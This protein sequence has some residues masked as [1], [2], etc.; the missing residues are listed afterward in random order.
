MTFLPLPPPALSPSEKHQPI[1]LS[2]QA[3]SQTSPGSF[4]RASG[5]YTI[6]V[7]DPSP[8]LCSALQAPLPWGQAPNQPPPE[9][10]GIS[11]SPG[12]SLLRPHHGLPPFHSFTPQPPRP[13]CHPAP[14]AGRTGEFT[15]PHTPPSSHPQL[16]MISIPRQHKVSPQTFLNKEGKR[17]QPLEV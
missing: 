4:L 8:L 13:D 16:S 2:S 11:E 9:G 7:L 6:W 15:R 17:D 1:T 14:R 12:P 5:V 3:W 10:R